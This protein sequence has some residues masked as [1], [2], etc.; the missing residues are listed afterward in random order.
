M[1]MKKHDSAAEQQE[2]SLGCKTSST[3]EV[4]N[5]ETY[6][7][8]HPPY[9]TQIELM[10][11]VYNTLEQ[12]GVG[13]I[14]SPTGTGKT[15][16]LLCPALTWMKRREQVLLA[17]KLV[18]GSGEDEDVDD[19]AKEHHLVNARNV[20]NMRLRRR[21]QCRDQRR[22]RASRAMTLTSSGTVHREK[23][24]RTTTAPE[25]AGSSGLYSKPALTSVESLEAELSLE[26]PLRLAAPDLDMGR[27][28]LADLFSP[29][30]QQEDLAMQEAFE[31]KL[32]VIFCS[33]THSQLAQVLKEIR[34]IPEEHLP[35]GF[36]VVTLGSRQNLCVNEAVK[37]R[38]RAAGHLNDL[39]RLATE[40]AGAGC[41]PS[42]AMAAAGLGLSCTLK[43][44]AQ[45][46]TDVCLTE[47]MDI[48]ALAQRAR[49]PIGG[50]CP[51]YGTRRA[52]PEADVLLVPYAS[53][54]NADMRQKLGIKPEGNVLIFDEA[55]NLLEAISE[56]HSV[57]LTATQA[58]VASDDLGLYAARYEARLSPGNAMR[59]RQ[60]RQLCIQLHRL[61][62]GL[63]QS[64]AQTVGAFLVSLGAD[65]FDLP[66][67]SR[68]LETTELA[69]KVRGFAESRAALSR[70]GSSALASSSSV[71]AVEGLL[72]ALKGSS[73]EDRIICQPAD[74]LQQ[75]SSEACLR[76]LS[77]DAEARFRELLAPARAVIFA[78]GT[79][80]PRAE[81]APLYCHGPSRP[82][83]NF[84]GSHV[85]P[86]DHIL[87]RFVT[88]GPAGTLLDFRKDMRNTPSQMSELRHIISG[89]AA[90]T[91]GGVVFFFP[92]FEYLAALAPTSAGARIAARAV[93][94]ERRS[95]GSGDSAG[96]NGS[97]RKEQDSEA[98]ILH[99]FSSAVREEGGALLLAVSGGKLSEGI[100]FKDDLCRLVAVV[101][102][103][104]PNA[105]DLA[106]L[107]KMRFLDGRRARGLPGLSGR[108]FYTARC[109]KAVNQCI[110][111]SIRHARDWAAI[112]LLD[113]RY[114]QP[115]INGSIS[116]WLAESASAARFCEV[117][118]ALKSFYSFRNKQEAPAR[119]ILQ[120]TPSVAS[121]EESPA[122]Q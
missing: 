39:C 113:H 44:Q 35:E 105:R 7:F 78:G 69:R 16:S 58:K 48:E 116:R 71:Y 26:A 24:R 23:I 18:P 82:V 95:L 107:E 66:D 81:F 14:E 45:T 15:L 74:A 73:S 22:L 68:F 77:L 38:A 70:A 4:Q 30:S 41:S 90:A 122:S 100:D 110:G 52:V 2:S 87:A 20:A 104:Y 89:V 112:L 17:E 8:P 63:E 40:R 62:G 42:A 80:E 43:K 102:L 56:A 79:L 55:H 91:P 5:A 99:Q 29:D 61:L 32:Q 10:A 67:L 117:D 65:H 59:L 37:S 11:R 51:Y 93:F 33:R 54:V 111:R 83:A 88:H 53:L 31:G 36:S 119:R 12:G 86:L 27:P 92:S 115:S 50:G 6:G 1:F 9:P 28:P 114:A 103:P 96:K 108:E 76:Y 98:N 121:V 49:A 94:V 75:G 97:G 101:G 3:L 72:A 85:V 84:S 19:W 106:L 57:A 120:A 46:M 109:M 13:V 34:S 21:R 64:S 60:L 47:L 118:N 25:S